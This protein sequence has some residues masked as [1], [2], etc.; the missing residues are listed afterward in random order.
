MVATAAN[1][2]VAIPDN[3]YTGALSSMACVNVVV[4]AA[5]CP[6]IITAVSVTA[7]LTH[8]WIGDL[9][10]K[11]VHPD[12]TI[13]TLM[14]RPGFIEALDNG[15]DAS[16]ESADLAAGFP[17]TFAS[18]APT[19]AETMGA[20][21][22]DSGSGVVCKDDSLCS[23]APNAGAA[24]AGTLATFNAKAPFGTWRFCVGDSGADDTGTINRV[25]LTI[26]R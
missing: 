23:Y 16:D 19:S 7:D 25:T 20:T 9:V 12:N 15:D 1:L 24:A 2:N 26:S 4:T 14:S 11:L 5:D 22:L 3:A 10:I 18:G 8:T 13:V 21:L 17:I 6:N